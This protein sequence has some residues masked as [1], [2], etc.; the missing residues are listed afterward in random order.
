MTEK[1]EEMKKAIAFGIDGA[2][3]EFETRGATDF[4]YREYARICGMIRMLEIVTGKN[5]YF[6][7]NGLHER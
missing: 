2:K 3:H 7:A 6:D 5:Y 1:I 4:Y